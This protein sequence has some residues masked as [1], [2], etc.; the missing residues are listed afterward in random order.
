MS[1]RPRL[2]WSRFFSVWLLVCLSCLQAPGA[3]AQSAEPDRAA[4][5]TLTIEGPQ[6]ITAWL[7]QH[8]E[9]QRY[10]DL[11]DL[12]DAELARL[13]QSADAQVQDLMATL[14]YFTASLRWQNL[15][16]TGEGDARRIVLNVKPGPQSVVATVHI[17]LQGDVA[18]NPAA[19]QQKQ[20]L[21]KQWALPAGKPFTQSA[22]SQAKSDALHRLTTENYPLGRL[23]GSQAQVDPETQSVRLTLTLDSGPRVLLGQAQVTGSERY[24]QEL[25]VRLARIRTGQAYR[26]SDLLEAQ[27]RLV[28]SG[29]YDSVFVS[30]E[31]EG[32]VQAMPV[33]IE[34][35]EALRQ[36]WV[37]G[38]GVRSDN[39]PRVSAEHTQHRVLGLDWRAVTKLAV[40]KT[41]QTASLDLLGQ[42]DEALWRWTTSGKVEHQVFT[43]YEVSSQRLRA[44]RT[45]LADRIDR[46]YYAQYD[47]SHTMGSLAD[48]RESLSAHYAWT[49]RR[50]DTLPFPSQGWGFGLE[51]GSGVTLGSQQTPYGRWMGKVLAMQP[52]WESDHKLSLRGELGGVVTRD[53]SGIPTTQLFLAGGDGSVRG[54][55]LSGIGVTTSPG[56]ISPGRYLA[57]GSAEWQIPIYRQSQRTDW[58]GTVF[59]DAGAVANT[60]SQMRAKVGAGIGARWRSPVG[61]LQI[62]L[63]QAQDT[64]QWRLHMSVGFKF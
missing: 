13:L 14:G 4:A 21:V 52:L 47:M 51:V 5:F 55:A 17:E 30:L 46:T 23:A 44:G 62:D 31:T 38:L 50:F 58:E 19:L 27:Q 12:D 26:Q 36:K 28:A 33:K 22:W 57:T 40:D 25:A 37:V 6:D 9:L 3:H 29:F 56:V 10:K 54:Y 2:P 11:P 59:V 34:L 42:P 7:L 18:H 24:G 60:P 39:G 35:K 63:A 64:H 15:P 41:L 1:R 48:T 8:L 61:P 53:A 49:W 45:Q 32:D 20:A 16:G 43:G